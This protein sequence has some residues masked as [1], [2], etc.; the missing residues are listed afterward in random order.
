MVRALFE[1]VFMSAGAVSCLGDAL[2]DHFLT[3]A[4]S[5]TVAGIAY[6]TERKDRSDGAATVRC[7]SASIDAYDVTV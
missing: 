6:I 7:R 1:D 4:T 2:V 5:L 3:S